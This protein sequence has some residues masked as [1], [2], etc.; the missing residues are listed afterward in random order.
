MIGSWQMMRRY[1]RFSWKKGF[2]MIAYFLL[3]GALNTFV[4]ADWA[5]VAFAWPFYLL[6]RAGLLAAILEMA[7]AYVVATLIV[8]AIERPWKKR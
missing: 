6:P 3:I 4:S 2:A 8:M 1:A 5:Y 7:Y